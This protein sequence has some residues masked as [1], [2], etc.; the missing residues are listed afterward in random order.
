M[1]KILILTAIFVSFSVAAGCR[2][3]ASDYVRLYKN[4]FDTSNE[5]IAQVI[6]QIN[7]ELKTIV[8]EIETN[9]QKTLT[10]IRKLEVEYARLEQEILFNKYI[11]NQIHS[12]VSDTTSQSANI[13]NANKNIELLKNRVEK[14]ELEDKILKDKVKE[15]E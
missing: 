12:L 3:S 10:N 7:S 8:K 15:D 14:D 6:N 11:S 4:D 13:V 9:N 5:K 2:G 1:R